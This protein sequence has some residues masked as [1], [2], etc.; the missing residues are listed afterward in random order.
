MNF[1]R[2]QKSKLPLENIPAVHAPFLFLMA[3]LNTSIWSCKYKSFLNKAIK[4]LHQQKLLSVNSRL[5]LHVVSDNNL[6]L[7]IAAPVMDYL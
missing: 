6:L 7:L 5:K 1:L 4:R 3:I 2:L